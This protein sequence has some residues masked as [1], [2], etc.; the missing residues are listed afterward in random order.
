MNEIS[1]FF[2]RR[3]AA[4]EEPPGVPSTR[5][6]GLEE[7][8]GL[9]DYWRVIKKHRRTIATFFLVMVISAAIF[10]FTTTP[11]YTAKA[12]IM[13]ERRNPQVV[14]IQQVLSESMGANDPEYY[15]SQYEILRSRSLAADVI[16]G[17]GLDKNPLFTG[18][19]GEL[20][21]S[22]PQVSRAA[23]DDSSIQPS[24]IDNYKGRLQI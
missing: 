8:P 14:N 12:T 3:T 10:V 2:I 7:A 22:A 20:R 4:P 5:V 21:T 23:A 17:L 15:Q 6:T 13:I 9:R 11:I 19:K 24:L 1:P 16:K 18:Q